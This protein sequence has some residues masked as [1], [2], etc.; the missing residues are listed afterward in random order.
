[1]LKNYLKIALR[2]FRKRKTH[3]LI[4]ILGLSTGMAV[5]LLIVLFI[6]DELGFDQFHEK[7]DRIYRVALERMYPGRST[8]Y[9][10]IPLS[11]GE[12]I[13]KEFPEVEESTRLFGNRGNGNFYV[14]I[15]DKV[16]EEKNVL[17]ADANF[18]RVFTAKILGGDP[19]TALQKPNSVVLNE[20]TAKKYF[21]SATEAMGKTLEVDGGSLLVTGICKDWPEHSHFLFDLLISSSSFLNGAPANYINFSATTYLLLKENASAKTLESKLPLIVQKYV[22]GQVEK[23]FGQTYQQF[24]ASGNGYHYYLQP[25]TKIHLTSDLEAEFR[26]NGSQRAVTIFAIIAVFIL[27]IACINFI[28]FSTARSVERAKEVG[29]RKTFGSERGS[30]VKQFLMES[31]LVCLISVLLAAVIIIGVLPLFNQVSGKHLETT[32][33]L[34]PTQ[35]IVMLAFSVVV[36][37][38][39]GIY[40]ALVL[41]SFK[42]IAV[43]RGKLTSSRYGRSLRNGLVGFQFFISVILIICTLVVN[44]QMG[45]VLGDKLGFKKDHIITVERTDLLDKNTN[46]FKNEVLKMAGVESISGSSAVPGNENYFGISFR[47]IGS[48]E[49]HTGRGITVDEKY[50]S[51]LGLTLAG[52]RFFSKDFSLDTLG[53]VLNEKAVTELGIRGNPVGARLNSPDPDLNAPNGD[54]Y[55]Y[56]VIGVLKDFHFQTLHQAI[57]PLFMMNARKF[58]TID[59]LMAIRI[60]GDNFSATVQA[61]ESKWKS[62]VKERPFH[63]SFLDQALAE[64]YHAEQ[65][66]KKIFSI[67]SVLAIFI[68]CIGLLGLIAYTTQQRIREIGIRKV[69]GASIPNIL[70]LLGKN[71]FTLILIASLIAFPVAWWAM[72]KWLQGFA[73][74]IDISWW[75]FLSAVLIAMAIAIVTISFQAIKAAIANPVKSLRTE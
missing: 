62:L 66:T 33:F 31:I 38:L 56:T 7:K 47:Q 29:I 35:L 61:L 2:N 15:G 28:N 3:A 43:L 16:F 11:I 74:R 27:F 49:T 6:R 21:G 34:H 75:I 71:F 65:T 70:V 26:P 55:V 72:H 17:N 67:F 44:R 23:L 46:A 52:G 1:M 73:Y 59:P 22:S 63:Y 20:T 69:L 19:A 51:T 13:K 58:G 25:L 18:F 68:A 8:S 37:I 4:N 36:G 10:I 45:Y 12:A 48:T 57:A 42:P 64:L 14:K 5:C 54:P 41:S 39:A 24:T 30:L 60:K 50:L 9:A 40:P 32:W 53:I